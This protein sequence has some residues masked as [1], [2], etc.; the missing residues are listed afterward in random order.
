MY[1]GEVVFREGNSYM[2]VESDLNTICLLNEQNEEHELSD[3]T[4][5]DGDPDSWDV[6]FTKIE[7]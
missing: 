3:T 2:R 1:S 7:D 5:I 6:H 4:L